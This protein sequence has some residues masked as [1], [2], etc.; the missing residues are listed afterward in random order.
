MRIPMACFIS[1]LVVVPLPARGSEVDVILEA[2]QKAGKGR[3]LFFRNVRLKYRVHEFYS[4]EHFRDTAEP[5]PS[6]APP[7]KAIPYSDLRFTIDAEYVRKGDLARMEFDGP[8]IEDGQ[9]RPSRGPSVNIFNGKRTVL[10][11]G[12]GKYTMSL[13]PEAVNGYATPW[14]LCGEHLLLSTLEYIRTKQIVITERKISPGATADVKQI[15]LVSA[16]KWRNSVWLLPELGYS[17][18]QFD[19]FNATGSR[20]SRYH[21][22]EYETIDGLPYPVRVTYSRYNGRGTNAVLYQESRLEVISITTRR[23]DIPNSLFEAEITKDADLYDR[24]QQKF[25]R[26][27]IRV[28]AVLDEIA[29]ESPRRREN[30][31]WGWVGAGVAGVASLAVGWW[32]WRRRASP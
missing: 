32:L 25:V 7:W 4:K 10:V 21:A 16:N 5:R 27:P 29:R 15:D 19:V 8:S 28:Q 13:R 26:N 9:L 11:N 24:D 23:G 18:R 14:D 22:I 2:I 1:I 17:V 3:E 31:F 6:G 30:R 20:V 12:A